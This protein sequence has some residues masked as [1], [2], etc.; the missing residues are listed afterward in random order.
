MMFRCLRAGFAEGDF[1]VSP[2]GS[3]AP[4]SLSELLRELEALRGRLDQAQAWFHRP[5][6][7][8]RAGALA[9]EVKRLCQEAARSG[10][11]AEAVK[12]MARAR[13]LLNELQALLGL[14]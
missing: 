11:E 2:A 4:P 1:E 6:D 14:H 8:M 12:S 13:D 7:S 5:Q 10:E 9:E 3:G